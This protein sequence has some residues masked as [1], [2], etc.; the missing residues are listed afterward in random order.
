MVPIDHFDT[1]AA[2]TPDAVALVEGEVA[3]TFAEVSRVSHQI[4]RAVSAGASSDEAV[5][6]VVYSPNDHRV[7]VAIVGIMRAG[8]VVVPVHAG[9][10][11]ETT[12]RCLDR[13]RPRY[14]LFHSSLAASVDVLRRQ[15]PSVQRWVCLDA[16]AEEADSLAAIATGDAPYDAAWIDASGNRD[17]PVYYWSTS[18]TTGEPKVVVDDVVSFD[19]TMML[20]RARQT[21]SGIRPVSL[22]VAPLSH[23]AGAHSVTILTL[24]GTVIV[25]RHF[26]ARAVLEAIERHQ[27]TDLWL[28]PTALYLL[29]EQ[30]DVH[31][32]DLSSLRHVQLGTAAVAPA[33]VRE[34][35]AVFGPC[36]SQPYGQ[37]ETGFVT[38]LDARLGAEWAARDPERLASAG[39]SLFVNR[40]AIMADDG[41]L[42]PPGEPGEIVVRGGGVKRYLDETA[43]REARRFGWHHTGDVGYVDDAGFLYIVGRIRDVVNMAGIKIPAAELEAV[44]AEL[45]AVRECAVIAVPDP[46]RGEVPKAIVVV[47][48]GYRLAAEAIVA[49]CR[50]RVGAGRA[51]ASVERWEALPRSP[52]GKVDKR[53][54]RAIVAAG[55]G[56]GVSGGVVKDGR[57]V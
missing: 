30:P 26:D 2:L 45:P 17:R 15:V 44:I 31:R 12:V 20:T 39:R 36:V 46:V 23:A 35:I 48:D 41:R 7:L 14:A 9:T 3:L 52:A 1:A 32:R 38:A 8:G 4:A 25:M 19:G 27:V 53:Q 13:V 55:A 29:L 10:P 21:A 40:V 18:G 24:G 47:K 16:P 33:K 43:T 54:I 11:I 22:A 6:V 34:A 42:L 50:R 49:H 51:P 57:S 28:P 5:P 56:V 37:I